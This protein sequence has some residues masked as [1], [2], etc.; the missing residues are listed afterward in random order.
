MPILNYVLMII[1]VIT[2]IYGQILVTEG[3]IEVIF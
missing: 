2:I 3:Y 1:S